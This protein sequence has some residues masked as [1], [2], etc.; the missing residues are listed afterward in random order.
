MERYNPLSPAENLEDRKQQALHQCNHLIKDFAKWSD[1][2]KARYKRLQVTIITL[3]V[4]TTILSALSAN[5]VLG[6]LDWVLSLL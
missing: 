4:F 5:K 1:R 2:H 6:Q 3:A